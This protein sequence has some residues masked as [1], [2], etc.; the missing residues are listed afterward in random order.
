VTWLRM[1]DRYARL[2]PAAVPVLAVLLAVAIGGLVILATGADPIVAYAALLRGAFGG[3]DAVAASLARSVPFVIA[4]L[5]VA[6]GLEAGLFNIGAEGQLIAGALAAAWVGTRDAV[7]ALPGVAAIPLV[8]E[9]RGCCTAR[10]P[11][12]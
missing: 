1:L 5:A 4:A 6:L 8:L 10:F 7:A 11:A 3:A 12:C 9:S 2:E